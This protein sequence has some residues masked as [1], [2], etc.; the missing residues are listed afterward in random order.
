MEKVAPNVHPK[1]LSTA[2]DAL[3]DSA[4]YKLIRCTYR[5]EQK[6]KHAALGQQLQAEETARQQAEQEELSRIR[7]EKHA[8]TR[9]PTV[10][11]T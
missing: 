3:K 1:I 9:Q 4:L 6:K 10:V 11:L 8:T 7:A 5:L 2:F